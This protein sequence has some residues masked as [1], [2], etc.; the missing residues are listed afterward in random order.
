MSASKNTQKKSVER[1]NI[2]QTLKGKVTN[3]QL[4]SILKCSLATISRMKKSP[5]YEEYQRVLREAVISHKNKSSLAFKPVETVKPIKTND[6]SK[7]NDL[8][9]I[10]V[11]NSQ[12]AESKKINNQL[13]KIVELLTIVSKRKFIF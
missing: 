5:T 4:G 7:L 2:V 11:L 3:A 6:L 10:S 12:L 13:E 9:C 1:Y 8:A